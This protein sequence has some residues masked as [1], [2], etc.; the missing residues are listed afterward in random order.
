MSVNVSGRQL[1]DPGF[2]ATVAALLATTGVAPA[3]LCLEFT[4]SVLLRDSEAL[5]AT[6]AELRRIGVRLGLDDFGTGYSSLGYL[7]N[8]ELDVLKIPREFV[9]QVGAA[10][11]TPALA[12][13]I[14]ALADALDLRVVAEGVETV[15]QADALR[16]MGCGMAQGWYFGRPGPTTTDAAPHLDAV[17]AVDA[18]GA[19]A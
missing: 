15:E 12:H 5:R 16:R 2:A 11:G 1:E 7:R 19:D 17:G 3:R 9:E 13:S 14:V 10:G 6:L 4:E 8:F 18:V